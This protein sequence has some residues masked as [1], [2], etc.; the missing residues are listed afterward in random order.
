MIYKYLYRQVLTCPIGTFPYKIKS[1]D[2]LASIANTFNTTIDSILLV[3]PG[4]VPEKLLIGQVICISQEKSKQSV[5][6]MMN[7][8][9][10]RKGETFAT[11]SKS[12]NV[13]VQSLL[14]ANPGINPL[15]LYE[16]LVI[17]VSVMPFLFRITISTTAKILTLYRNGIFFKAYPVATGKPT[18]PTPIGTFTIVNKQVN[19][20]G[21]FGSRWMGLSKPHYGI[22]GTNK[23]SSIGTAASNGCV[24][25]YA[26]DVEDLFNFVSVGTVVKIF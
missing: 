23:P 15:N 12:F 5:C 7:T 8:Y 1:G 22:H 21:P 6:P 3:N 10:I 9:V 19:P 2:I 26:N 13:P 14:N 20:G 18:T 4:I 17:C 16:G 25:M 11:I 24:R